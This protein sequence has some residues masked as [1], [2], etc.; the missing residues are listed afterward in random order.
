MNRVITTIVTPADSLDLTTTAIVKDELGIPDSDTTQDTRIGRFITQASALI[1]NYCDRIF[2][3]QTYQDEIRAGW[4]ASCAGASHLAGNRGYYGSSYG[5]AVRAP[6]PLVVA[7]RPLLTITSISEDGTALT[8]GTDFEL[9]LVNSG[10]FRLDDG[11]NIMPWTANKTVVVYT[12]GYSA[13]PADVVDAVL[14]LITMRFKGRDRDPM[15]RERDQPGL[16]H[17]VFWV[18]G[19]PMSGSVPQEIAGILDKYCP[20]GIS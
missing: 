3:A 4:Y 6:T 15:L 5:F 8:A 17:Q 13:I 1:T 10:I 12:S 18:G 2:P 9:D 11:G 7:R 14:R 16:G 19:P 20:P